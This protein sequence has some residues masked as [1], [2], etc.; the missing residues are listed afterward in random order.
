M[1]DDA[2]KP[3]KAIDSPKKKLTYRLQDDEKNICQNIV[4]FGPSFLR[5]NLGWKK[6]AVKEFLARR[7]IQHEIQTLKEQYGDRTGIQERTQFF[8]QSRINSM[9]PAAVN[10]LAKALRGEYVDQA[11]GKTV[12]P[13]TEAQF[14]AATEV[15]DRA[16]IQGAKY[17]GNDNVPTIDARSVSLSLG[18]AVAENTAGLDAES[19]EKVRDVFGKVLGKVRATLVSRG[20]ADDQE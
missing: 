7:E 14:K 5:R 15:L 1:S 19:R 11:S 2:E 9:V 6:I 13:P 8:G 3:R 10:V 16:N 17:L 20:G 4:V 12:L 18:G